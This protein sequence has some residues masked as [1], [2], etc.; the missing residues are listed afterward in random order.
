M[1]EK[2]EGVALCL[3][4]LSVAVALVH[5]SLAENLAKDTDFRSDNL[6][7][8]VNWTCIRPQADRFEILNE[9]GPGGGHVVRL[10]LTAAGGFHQPGFKYVDNEPYRMSAWVRTKNLKPGNV[11]LIAYDDWLHINVRSAAFPS[12][13]DGKWVKVEWSDKMFVNIKHA[14]CYFGVSAN[15]AMGADEVLDICGPEIEPLS[16]KARTETIVPQPAKAF[17]PRIIPILPKLADVDY[18]VPEMT[19][20]YPG[21][22]K[23]SGEVVALVDGE[24]VAKGALGADRRVK[25][26]LTGVTEGRHR[27]TVVA[28]DNGKAVAK[29]DYTITVHRHPKGAAAGMRLNNFV[30]ELP[31]ERTAYGVYFVAPA[32]GWYYMSCDNPSAERMQYLDPGRHAVPFPTLFGSKVTVRKV[33]RLEIGGE[34]DILSATDFTK[35]WYGIDFFDRFI[36][37]GMN[38]MSMWEWERKN[39]AKAMTLFEERGIA[40]TYSISMNSGKDVWGDPVKLAA[41]ITNC[42]GYADRKLISLDETSIQRPRKVQYAIAEAL[43]SLADVEDLYLGIDYNDTMR[44]VFTDKM[45]APSVLAALANCGGG[46]GLMRAEAYSAALPTLEATRAQGIDFYPKLQASVETMAPV[47]AG[48]LLYH[49]SGYIAP[50]LWCDYPASTADFK[51]FFADLVRSFATNPVYRD[52]PGLSFSALSRIDEELLRWM[53]K[54][55]RYYAIEGHTDDICAKYGYRYFPGHLVN[56]D[57]DRKLEGWDV[58]PAADG[59][60]VTTNIHAFAEDILCFRECENSRYG[61][62]FAVMKRG[63]K[64]PNVLRQQVKGLTPGKLYFFSCLTMDLDDVRK[65]GSVVGPTHFHVDLQGAEI[66]RETRF[67]QEFATGKSRRGYR[68]KPCVGRVTDRFVFRARG[69]TA[70]V[71][72]CDWDDATTPGGKIGGETVVTYVICRP[73]YVE[74]E[75]EFREI[76][77]RWPTNRK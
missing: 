72:L 59:S 73:Y 41:A 30:T 53:S 22:L 20:Y 68:G 12:D 6:G 13:T 51:V 39:H 21:D 61:D 45:M 9:C 35:Y 2:F 55:F 7:G 16:E 26:L 50:Y 33:V 3:A 10:R 71:S 36:R 67:R 28:G 29:N 31:I 37:P 69:E 23:G 40:Q 1:G 15:A 24:K 32:K 74:S 63:A 56:G 49:V 54:V 44:R 43:W 57:F 65:P 19:F 70:S 17:A 47:A 11:T 66:V 62:T 42:S 27:L 8:V 4:S 58:R 64:G 25:L 76:I 34:A 14:W 46:T 38:T 18:D 75:D 77:T 5:P 48:S 52:I 60:V